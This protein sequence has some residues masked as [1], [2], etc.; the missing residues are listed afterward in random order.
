[1]RKEAGGYLKTSHPTQLPIS[2]LR[3]ALTLNFKLD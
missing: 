1:M 3:A 2:K